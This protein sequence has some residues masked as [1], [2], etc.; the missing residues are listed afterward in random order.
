MDDK[1]TGPNEDCTNNSKTRIVKFALGII[2]ASLVVFFIWQSS[3]T[4]ELKAQKIYVAYAQNESIL[5]PDGSVIQANADSKISYDESNW[6]TK[7]VVHLEGE[8]FF[9]II[10]GKPFTVIT[11]VAKIEVLGTS[12][13]IFSRDTEFKVV[14]KTGEVKVSLH[15]IDEN[16]TLIKN[17]LAY[18]F[19][20]TFIKETK[21]EEAKI[22]WLNDQFEFNNISLKKVFREVERQFDVDIKSDFIIQNTFY[23]GSFKKT[24]LD[25]VLD[26]ICRP[27]NLTYEKTDRQISIRKL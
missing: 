20:G 9:K 15:D 26:Q 19:D 10:K 25:E 4:T 27:M 24:T 21:A 14:C 5:L 22:P 7:R 8:A 18:L 1:K 11:P 17:E 16:R 23:K 13:N 2:L 6:S 12:F 3:L